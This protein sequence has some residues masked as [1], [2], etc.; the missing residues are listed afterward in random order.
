MKSRIVGVDD[1]LATLADLKK[2]T[3]RGVGRR[4][5]VPAAEQLADAVRERAPVLTG[6]LRGKVRVETQGSKVAVVVEDE[7]A[8]PNEYGTSDTPIQPFFR[9][10][11]DTE[12]AGMAE[13]VGRDLAAETIKTAKRVARRGAQ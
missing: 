6:E 8:V 9:P 13:T 7:A 10:A 4:S 2:G 3:R 12:R 11:I 1:C 5:L